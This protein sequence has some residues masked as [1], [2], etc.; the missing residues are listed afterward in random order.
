MARTNDYLAE[1]SKIASDL[2][3]S[4]IDRAIEIL[5]HAW[6]GDNQV[7]VIGNGGSAIGRGP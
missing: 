2:D 5:Y 6:K 4:D 7:F 3:R 1:V